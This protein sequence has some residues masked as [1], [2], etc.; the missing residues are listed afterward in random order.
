MYTISHAAALAGVSVELLR[1][2][3]RRYGLV[4]PVRTPAGYRLYDDAAI[5]RLRHMRTLVDSGWSART[6][7]DAI[8][9]GEAAA[10]DGRDAGARS[11]V[12]QQP[13][14]QEELIAQFESAEI[15][16]AHV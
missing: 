8:I 11:D 5:D 14:A 10:S 7:A 16:R 2:W 15:G 3:E 13:A 12:A 9:S 6:A 1:A 4:S